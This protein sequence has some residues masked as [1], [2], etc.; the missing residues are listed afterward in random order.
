ENYD[1]SPDGKSALADVVASTLENLGNSL[2]GVINVQTKIGA[3]LNTLEGAR[4][5]H[6]DTQLVNKKVMGQ[7]RDLDYA[8]AAT[9][10]SQQSLILQAAQQSFIRVS[11]LNLFDR[12]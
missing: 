7:L 4:D 8:E 9:R 5:M 11:R 10:L 2:T 1:G 6:L 3:R 12:L